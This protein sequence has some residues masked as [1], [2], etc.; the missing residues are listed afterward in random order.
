[1]VSRLLKVCTLALLALLAFPAPSQGP[2]IY[3]QLG[4]KTNNDF[5]GSC[6]LAFSPDGKRL[7]AV[8]GGNTI[9]I[10]DTDSGREQQTLVG[11]VEAVK[12][13]AFLPDSRRLVSG[14]QDKVV[15]LWD[16]ETGKLLRAFRGHPNPVRYLDVSADGTVLV[17]VEEKMAKLW[18]LDDG[19][20][21]TT[22]QAPVVTG[23]DS[24]RPS[25]FNG[26]QCSPDSSKVLFM[27]M[28]GEVLVA[29]VRERR[30]IKT[31][32]WP[33]VG[34][35]S[36][37]V[38]LGPT[39]EGKVVIGADSV[40][41]YLDLDRATLTRKERA[42]GFYLQYLS[43]DGSLIAGRSQKAER[44]HVFDADLK[45]RSAF[46]LK[47][48]PAAIAY[49]PVRQQLAVS[50]LG[51]RLVVF[52]L[53]SGREILDFSSPC[54]GTN[55]ATFSKEGAFVSTNE[56]LPHVL[57]QPLSGM[58]THRWSLREAALVASFN[59]SDRHKEMARLRGT[60]VPAD[61]AKATE[62]YADLTAHAVSPEAF[63]PYDPQGQCFY[64][65]ET[66]PLN[67]FTGSPAVTIFRI[68]AKDA[69]DIEACFS[70]NRPN[71]KVFRK[72]TAHA[73]EIK[74]LAVT[75]TNNLIATGSADQTINLFS[76]RDPSLVRTLRGHLGTITGLTFSPDG[77]RLLSE[78]DDK[79]CRLWDVATGKE[80]GRLIHFADGEWIVVTPEG[81]YN[82]SPEGDRHLNVKVGTSVYGI[83]N[84]R[85]AFFRPD[86]VKIALAGGSMEGFRTLAEIKPAPRVSIVQTPASTTS[87]AF[88]VTLKLEERGGG[89]GD[90]RLFLNGSAVV[91][92]NGRGVK[93]VAGEGGTLRSYAL[94]LSPGA[95]VIRATAF[96][97]DN[98]MQSNDATL[99]VMAIFTATHKPTLHALVIGIQEFRNPKL[100]L[101]Y[102][103]ADAKLFAETL[104]KGATELFEQVKITS[105]TSR[106]ATTR[107]GVI[108]AMERYQAINPDDVF[109]LYLA[110]HGTVD[111]GEYYLITSNVGPVSTQ[112][113]KADALSQTLLKELVANVP[114]TKKLVLIDTCNAGQLGQAMQKALLT[115]GMSE[116]AA[117][118]VLS[119]AVG[120]TILSAST[121]AQEALEG[122]EGHGLFTWTL[123]QGM[124]GKAD[125]G[126]SGIV[127]TSELAAYVELEVPELAERIFKKAQFPTVA[128][129]GNGFPVGKVQ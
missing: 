81:Y 77:T 30:F 75:Y 95:N 5:N 24:G 104:R 85:E 16:V 125:K 2:E 92:D 55:G 87:E 89:I 106:E 35:Y 96:N 44:E 80:L 11:P 122:Y 65:V 94:K 10:W 1:M 36:S 25:P 28:R 9:R 7:A 54:R 27:N 105:L 119:R 100:T 14:G 47:G 51:D 73:Q 74:A 68:E 78:S 59:A 46:D 76:Y 12:C 79:T 107:E 8:S 112:R 127:L 42:K 17:T 123:T 26:V 56:S 49:S 115:R 21:I 120:S 37:G 66:V 124:L 98:S 102:P 29:G 32:E 82:A 72:F 69:N 41:V 121:S 23:D 38:F 22:L 118:K 61:A 83:D 110:S 57:G 99:K 108:A 117:I 4:F 39:P 109:I 70:R 60:G 86:L 101:K 50:Y 62:L 40:L 43:P 97:A 15:R 114:S 128:I 34:V 13:L 45:E 129:S 84:Y 91:L 48:T 111:E 58:M 20:L 116:E 103:V 53:A 71:W 126:R 113:L 19:T 3:L 52:D 31:F 33:A 63:S 6:E 90:L 88:K 18:N 64:C 67:I 93:V